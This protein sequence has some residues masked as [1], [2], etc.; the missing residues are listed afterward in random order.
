MCNLAWTPAVRH[1]V[2]LC[3]LTDLA[4][5]ISLHVFLTLCIYVWIAEPYLDTQI[6]IMFF[7]KKSILQNA[8]YLSYTV[9]WGYAVKPHRKL[10]LWVL[11]AHLIFQ[12]YWTS[13]HTR[14]FAKFWPRRW[15]HRVCGPLD[16]YL[17]DHSLEGGQWH[18]FFFK[19]L[20]FYFRPC[21][22]RRSYDP[23]YYIFF[24]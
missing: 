21:P 16:L 10:K 23:I 5:F 8:S 14:L 24:F 19:G 4:G 9:A 3:Y 7:D 18:F 17:L 11:D 22:T 20:C 12:F 1:F 13:H 15:G 6:Q 2:T